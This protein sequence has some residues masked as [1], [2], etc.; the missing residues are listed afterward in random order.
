MDCIF[1]ISDQ[2]EPVFLDTVQI[3]KL[4]HFDFPIMLEIGTCSPTPDSLPKLIT[5]SDIKEEEE[6]VLVSPPLS[7]GRIIIN[8]LLQME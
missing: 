6:P 4:N 1:A 5:L 7:A 8:Y 3:Y 2:L